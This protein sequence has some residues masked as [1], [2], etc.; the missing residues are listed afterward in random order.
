MSSSTT[1]AA[2]SGDTGLQRIPDREHPG[3]GLGVRGAERRQSEPD[4]IREAEVGD[5]AVGPEPPG[6]LAEVG[7]ADRDVSAA[8]RRVA[9]AEQ[10]DIQRRE[11]LVVR[12]DRE[13][14]ERLRLRAHAVDPRLLDEVD[15]PLHREHRGHRGRAAEEL[16][17]AVGGDVL[18]AHGEDVGC[19]PP[20]LDRLPQQALQVVA[21]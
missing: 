13:R 14:G 18:R 12:P 20:A 5:D 11:Q 4:P 19:A 3:D 1:G 7:V 10:A 8:S 2:G 6:D 21:E 17:D 9:R 16:T 15:H